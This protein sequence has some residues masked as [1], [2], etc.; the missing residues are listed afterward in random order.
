MKMATKS[1]RKQEK[2]KSPPKVIHTTIVFLTHVIPLFLL[3]QQFKV[4]TNQ[5]RTV[6][7]G[8]STFSFLQQTIISTKF[9]H[10]FISRHN[11]LLYLVSKIVSNTSDSN[12]SDK[13][14]MEC[15]ED[16]STVQHERDAESNAFSAF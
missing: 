14:F 15:C 8:K 9:S 12:V 7:I 3:D 4:L 5:L 13:I 1:R 2:R 6:L 10:S 11:G 16:R